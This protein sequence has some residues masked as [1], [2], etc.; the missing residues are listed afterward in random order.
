MSGCIQNLKVGEAPR[1]NTYP[2][3]PKLIRE[4]KTHYESFILKAKAPVV[5]R[6]SATTAAM[7]ADSTAQAW[8]KHPA[9]KMQVTRLLY[10]A[11]GDG[12]TSRTEFKSMLAAAGSSLDSNLVFDRMDRDG[13]GFL[14]EAEIN[15]I[16]QDASGIARNR[17]TV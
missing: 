7:D 2:G 4:P 10:D 17:G 14:S 12:V 8:M 9:N 5:P 1:P 11:D 15:A 3:P 6:A 16:G 13:D